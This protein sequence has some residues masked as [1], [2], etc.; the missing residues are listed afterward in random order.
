MSALADAAP[1]LCSPEW[2]AL[3]RDQALRAAQLLRWAHHTGGLR[4]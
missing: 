1:V 4:Q 2:F 3:R